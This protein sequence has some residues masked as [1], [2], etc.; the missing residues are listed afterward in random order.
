MDVNLELLFQQQEHQTLH[1]SSEAKPKSLNLVHSG[2]S[3]RLVHWDSL[4]GSSTH[5]LLSLSSGFSDSKGLGWDL[6]IC[7]SAKFLGGA[8]G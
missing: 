4:E 8:D 6:R 7:V 3:Q 5:Q 1:S 2:G